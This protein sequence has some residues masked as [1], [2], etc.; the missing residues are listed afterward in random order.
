MPSASNLDDMCPAPIEP[1]I[2]RGRVDEALPMIKQS[3]N[4]YLRNYDRIKIGATTDPETRWRRG[5][6][7][8]TWEKMILLYETTFPGSTR[9]ME[10]RLIEY[11]RSTNFRVRPENVLPGGESI[12]DGAEAYWVYVTVGG[13]E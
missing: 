4:G 8:D 11:A 7:D 2:T 3:L 5:Y 12:K 13:R 6:S 1:K 10:K 9:S